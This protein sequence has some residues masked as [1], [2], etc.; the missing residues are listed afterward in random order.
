MRHSGE[1]IISTDKRLLDFELIYNFISRESYWGKQRSR[2]AMQTAIDHS[3]FC[4]GLYREMGDARQQ[5]GFARVLT[6][7][8]T[9]GYITDLFVLN[10]YR[11]Q[12]L[13]KR[14]LQTIVDF[15]D[16]KRLRRITLLTKTPDF[17]LP[18]GF[19]NFA[20]AEVKFMERKA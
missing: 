6:D 13:G 11:G 17:Y 10:Q 2:E 12:G 7:F 14:L 3:T 19:V 5:A 8:V 4:F 16:L 9:F 18:A 1:Y 15:P 20:Q